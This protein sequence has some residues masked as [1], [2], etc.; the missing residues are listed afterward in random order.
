[1]KTAKTYLEEAH[2]VGLIHRDVKPANIFLTKL[3]R[4]GDL[5]KLVDFGLVKDVGGGKD[6]G[7]SMETTIAGTPHYLSPEAIQRP[8]DVDARSDIYALGAVA[9]FL[10]TG[11]PP[12][13]QGGL[14]EK[15]MQ[16]QYAEPKSV[17]A[18]RD[19]VPKP[20]IEACE[21]MMAKRPEDRCKSAAVVA[22]DLLLL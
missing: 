11:Q 7:R 4:G 18:F 12:F 21:S 6:P 20:L 10:L 16:H 15:L 3:R 5:A 9:Y 1:M 13:P 19:D 22:Q 2:A 17:S 14:S 8:E